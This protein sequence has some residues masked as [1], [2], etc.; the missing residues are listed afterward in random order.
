MHSLLLQEQEPEKGREKGKQ[1]N[2]AERERV[3]QGVSGRD[4]LFTQTVRTPRGGQ[5]QKLSDTQVHVT[6]VNIT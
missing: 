4:M 5:R 6:R 1:G 3:S 2:G